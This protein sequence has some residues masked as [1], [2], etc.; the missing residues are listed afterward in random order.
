MR[1]MKWLAGN[2]SCM[3]GK[4]VAGKY[5]GKGGKDGEN[6]KE[7][8]GLRGK[9]WKVGKEGCGAKRKNPLTVRYSYV[10]QSGD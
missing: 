10:I 5:G 1:L 6:W 9:K 4:K 2:G 3:A 7:G 8:G